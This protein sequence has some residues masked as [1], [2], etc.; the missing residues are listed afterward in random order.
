MKLAKWAIAVVLSTTSCQAQAARSKAAAP[1]R[2]GNAAQE[3]VSLTNRE[4]RQ[5]GLSPLKI[6]RSCVSAITG[7]VNDMARGGFL[8]HEGGDG[9]GAY[10]RYR[11]HNPKARGAGENVAYNSTGTG[12]S[13][14]RQW[15]NSS[16]HRSNIL[17]PNYKGIGVAVRANCSERSGGGRC[18]YYAGQCF[19]Q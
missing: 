19:S 10:E 18:T 13:F 16:G 14:M 2:G 9:R 1:P 7:H 8:S 11:Q 15:L 3:I 5:H 4:R 17:S 6:D 12:E